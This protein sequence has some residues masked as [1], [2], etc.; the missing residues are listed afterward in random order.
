MV[1]DSRAPDDLDGAGQELS[2]EAQTRVA[3]EA[4]RESLSLVWNRFLIAFKA[5]QLSAE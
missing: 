3:R 2:E 1:P 5:G 4:A